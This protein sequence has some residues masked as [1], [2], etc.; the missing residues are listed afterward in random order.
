MYVQFLV[1]AGICGGTTAI[2]GSCVREIG[3]TAQF[4]IRIYQR[5]FNQHSVVLPGKKSAREPKPESVLPINP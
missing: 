3:H 5:H 2:L 4:N 1:K